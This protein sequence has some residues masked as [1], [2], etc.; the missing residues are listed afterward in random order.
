M[1]LKTT[2]KSGKMLCHDVLETCQICISDMTRADQ[3]FPLHCPTKL[4]SFNVCLE[5]IISMLLSEA[6]GYQLASDGSNQLKFRVRCPNCCVR[7]S[8]P[9]RP[10]Q[11]IVPYVATLRQAYEVKDFLD[12]PDGIL[13]A[14]AVRRKRLF[15]KFTTVQE[16]KEAVDVYEDYCEMMGKQ[17]AGSIDLA[18]F[19]CLPRL[20]VHWGDPSL[21]QNG[22]EKRLSEAEQQFLT[23]LLCSG[24]PDKVAQ[25]VVS[26][27][28]ME[29]RRPK[30]LS[31]LQESRQDTSEGEGGA[32]VTLM[33]PHDF[34]SALFCGGNAS[35][36]S[37]CGNMH[38]TVNMDDLISDDNSL[39]SQPP[40]VSP[41]STMA[42]QTTFDEPLPEFNPNRPTSF[43]NDELLQRMFGV[44]NGGE[45]RTLSRAACSFRS[46]RQR[47]SSRLKGLPTPELVV[48][49]AVELPLPN[50]MP[51]AAD[52]P[53]Y[54]PKGWYKSLKF[55]KMDGTK[56]VIKEVSGRATKKGLRPGD[57]L[58]HFQSEA[59]LTKEQFN[60][61]MEDLYK[62]NPNTQCSLVVNADR[63]VADHLKT[64]ALLMRLMLRR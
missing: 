64:R 36:A 34:I 59:V 37:T 22:E 55:E 50:R 8:L 21:F 19:L 63:E 32:A 1:K 16:V 23:Q 33:Q 28:A 31:P 51:R 13:G 2:K 60:Q 29:K 35:L 7:Y 10:K 40:L 42:T 12:K 25:G 30:P 56:L 26:L 14:D 3:L 53:V 48:P 24:D 49:E 39:T 44:P 17:A 27:Q 6:D 47:T 4:C 62:K 46:M 38:S 43:S 15:L 61:Q 58:T 54:H 41:L 18:D 5:C 52:I 57:V 45:N 9:R 11:S 20:K